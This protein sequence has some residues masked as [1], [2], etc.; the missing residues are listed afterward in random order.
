MR[1]KG[2]H[3]ARAYDSEV[4]DKSRHR[5]SLLIAWM[6]LQL[7]R[8]SPSASSATLSRPS[9]PLGEGFSLLGLDRRPAHS[10]ELDT[11]VFPRTHFRQAAAKRRAQAKAGE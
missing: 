1:R 11:A 7:S 10:R 5:G 2:F 9:R 6:K 8:L 3:G 4:S